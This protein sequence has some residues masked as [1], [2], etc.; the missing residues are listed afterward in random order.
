MILKLKYSNNYQESKNHK[1]RLIAEIYQLKL[2]VNKLHSALEENSDQIK[3]T[4]A[5]MKKQ[6]YFMIEYYN[7]LLERAKQEC[8]NVD[9]EMKNM[10]EQNEDYVKDSSS[11]N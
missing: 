8:I 4:K 1:E 3:P 6:L 9:K 11:S 2:R 10:L 5:L 7:I